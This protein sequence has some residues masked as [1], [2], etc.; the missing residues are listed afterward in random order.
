MPFK[1]FKRYKTCK[2]LRKTA[3]LMIECIAANRKY[4][5]KEIEGEFANGNTDIRPNY[6][7]FF[8]IASSRKLAAKKYNIIL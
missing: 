7:M 5:K 4:L 8:T 1:I 6:P 2:F 3:L